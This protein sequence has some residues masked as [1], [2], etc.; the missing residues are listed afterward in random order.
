[1]Q[2]LTLHA[3]VWWVPVFPLL[4]AVALQDAAWFA[5]GVM[6]IFGCFYL[7]LIIYAVRKWQEFKGGL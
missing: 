2:A 7:S 3:K 1:M 4:L 5:L 6:T